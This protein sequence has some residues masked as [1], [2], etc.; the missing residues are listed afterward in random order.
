MKPLHWTT[1]GA[2]RAMERGEEMRAAQSVFAAGF[3]A[4]FASARADASM[5]PSNYVDDFGA[6]SPST[7][8]ATPS[9][10]SNAHA[11]MIPSNFVDD[12]GAVPSAEGPSGGALSRSDVA[13]V[14]G[15]GGPWNRHGRLAF[16]RTNPN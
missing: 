15:S 3:I 13:A 2:D 11:S 16:A 8:A 10:P 4:V 1:L 12:F 7:K 6:L 9:A 5:I 14:P